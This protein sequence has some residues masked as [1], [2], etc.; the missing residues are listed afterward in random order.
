MT[1]CLALS[2]GQDQTTQ[3][4]ESYCQ[5]AL[6]IM[7]QHTETTDTTNQANRALLYAYAY[8]SME[9]MYEALTIYK[10]TL[11]WALNRVDSTLLDFKKLTS[12][13]EV[14]EFHSLMIEG[15]TKEQAGL[16]KLLSYYTSVLRYGYG[17][18]KE[19]DDGNRLLGQATNIWTQATYEFEDI[20]EKAGIK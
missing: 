12:P 9:Q 8:G 11:V 1:L 17:Y 18:D 2:C 16:T 7:E 10:D 20:L 4:L 19:L 5:D 3:E 15:L 6:P 14:R 13:S